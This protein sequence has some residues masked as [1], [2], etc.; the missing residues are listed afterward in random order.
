MTTGNRNTP[1]LKLVKELLAA[2][3]NDVAEMA[4]NQ[5]W[6]N[7]AITLDAIQMYNQAI[8]AIEAGITPEQYIK[9]HGDVNMITLFSQRGAPLK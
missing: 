8:G 7:F 3:V 6:D 4:E 9:Q 5:D 1:E 2:D